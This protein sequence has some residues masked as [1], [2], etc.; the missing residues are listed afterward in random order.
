MN[1]TLDSVRNVFNDVISGN[2]SREC[3]DRW[4]HSVIKKSEENSVIFTPESDKE[5]IWNGIMY[6][7]GI[8]LEESPGIYLHTDDE[9]R[10][11]MQT[12]IGFSR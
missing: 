1:I 3:A 6:L 2:I 8:D 10:L 11:A 4:A 12:K 9:I 7:Y 5:K